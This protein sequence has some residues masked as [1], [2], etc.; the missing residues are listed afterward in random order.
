MSVP[1]ARKLALTLAFPLGG[2]AYLRVRDEPLRGLVVAVL[3]CPG[4]LAYVVAWGDGSE[5]T[6]YDFELREGPEG[7]E[8]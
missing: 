1:S 8:D 5:S 2:E 3:V 7:P 6:H 4:A